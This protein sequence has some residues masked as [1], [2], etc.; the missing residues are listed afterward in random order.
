MKGGR[1]QIGC[2][3]VNLGS[4]SQGGSVARQ[5]QL[6]HAALDAGVTVF[7]TADAYGA[8]ASEDVLGRALQG[9]RSEVVLA[10]KG[11]FLFR[12]R[13]AVERHGRRLLAPA[14]KK[15]RSRGGE[16]AAGVPV[17]GGYA[18][19]DF[20]PSHL[21]RALDQ[22]LRRLR[23]DH[24]DV[25]QLHGPPSVLPELIGELE[26]LRS[27]GKVR[28]FGVGAQSVDS[29]RQWAESG[30]ALDVLQVPFGVLDPGTLDEIGQRDDACAIWARGVLGGGVI[31][32]AVADSDELAGHHQ[33]PTL[34][35]LREVS[36]ASGL[37]LDELAIRWAVANSG[38]SVILL[39]MSSE[40]HLR[41]NIG[42]VGTG[43]LPD[44]V[45]RAVDAAVGRVSNDGPES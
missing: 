14:V 30:V 3:C 21:R 2:G 39:G 28:R 11:G 23:T 31:A 4:S 34:A 20:S 29:A 15:V 8:G 24:V 32:L 5:T 35:A 26:D 1:V 27:A 7:D 44:D 16:G 12:H 25:Y 10:T 19:Q 42:L 6:V 41:R 17:P 9:R 38:L 40:Q 18:E 45:H 37:A 43:P 33:Q 22:S 36:S 13:S